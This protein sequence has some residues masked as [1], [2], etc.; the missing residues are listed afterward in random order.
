MNPHEFV[1]ATAVRRILNRRALT[2][3]SLSRF[4]R[5]FRY[6]EESKNDRQ[7][8]FDEVVRRSL[9]AHVDEWLG[10]GYSRDGSEKPFR[11][12]LGRT[13]DASRAVKDY[14][15]AYPPRATVSL[16]D[17][18]DLSIVLTEPPEPALPGST[19]EEIGAQAHLKAD[20][21]FVAALASGW[22]YRLFKCPHCQRYQ[23][24]KDPRMS[25]KRGRFCRPHL[26][27]F[28]ALQARRKKQPMRVSPTPLR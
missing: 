18:I 17:T 11:R 7:R 25:Y 3:D 14:V 15:E 2:E 1:S 6:Q 22:K 23:I 28:G 16:N 8:C 27:E 21:L 13:L 9:A 12:S 19:F 26:Q 4:R 24:G 5:K 10:T 20:F